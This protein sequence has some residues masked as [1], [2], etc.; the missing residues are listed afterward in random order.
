MRAFAIKSSDMRKCPLNRMDAPHFREDGTC[1]CVDQDG[2]VIAEIV[3]GTVEAH[4]RCVKPPGH[5][6]PHEC[7]DEE[8]CNGA[9]WDDGETFWIY[10]FPG[11]PPD[12][13]E[14]EPMAFGTRTEA[15]HL[16]LVSPPQLD[17]RPISDLDFE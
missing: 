1:E 7:K 5:E 6:P 9:W 17:E 8:T 4:C 16:T 10:R 13:P 2:A 11:T 15:P 14:M 12:A 3:C